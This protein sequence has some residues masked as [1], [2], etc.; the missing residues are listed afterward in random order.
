[1]FYI[2]KPLIQPCKV[3][4]ILALYLCWGL[5]MS[6]SFQTY[7]SVALIHKGVKIFYFLFWYQ[8]NQTWHFNLTK[9]LKNVQYA[10]AGRRTKVVKLEWKKSIIFLN[11][12]SEA[13]SCIVCLIQKILITSIKKEKTKI[14][15]DHSL[16]FCG[17]SVHV[18]AKIRPEWINQWN[19]S[20]ID[21]LGLVICRLNTS[22]SLYRLNILF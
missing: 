17:N 15:P 12:S 4:C 20:I 7:F 14:T 11:S 18:H 21:P 10:L 16:E 13:T 19:G 9:Q 5:P 1:M 8:E 6:F 22:A 2:P 3:M